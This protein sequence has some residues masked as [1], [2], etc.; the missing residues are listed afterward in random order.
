MLM[1][2]TTLLRRLRDYRER[3]RY[4]GPTVDGTR[5][6][7]LPMMAI[8]MAAMA[9]MYQLVTTNAMAVNFTTSDHEFQL[10]SNYVQGESAAG[11]L[12]QNNG[13]SAASQ[14]GVAELGIKSAKLA[15]LCGIAK[16]S[17]PIVGDVS[18]M[19]IAGVPV[20]GAFSDGANTSTDGAGAAITYDANG[21]LTGTSLSGAISATDLFLNTNVLSGYGNLIS[22][23]NLGQNAA[24]VAGVAQLNNGT[25]TWPAG[26][27]APTAGGFGLTAQNLNVGGLDGTSYGLNLAGQITLPKLKIVVA[28]GDKS[29]TDCP[30]QAGS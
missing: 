12:A 13:Y 5:R 3:R 8:G 4:D 30:T 9:G 1:K 7:A 15:G 19:L 18:L 27:T 2:P 10:Y 16:E 25:G 11:F 28:P 6:R 20:Q 21:K 17:L 23:L 22:G 26:Q 29:Q 14:V 24:D